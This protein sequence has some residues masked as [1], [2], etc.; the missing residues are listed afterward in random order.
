MK[1]P[2][3]MRRYVEVNDTKLMIKEPV[4]LWLDGRAFHS[5]TR[6]LGKPFSEVLIKT[7]HDTMLEMSK[8]IQGVRLAYTQSDEV[9]IL[10]QDWES[11]E[12]S[13]WFDYR[14][15]KMTSIGASM[16]TA[17]FS[18]FW[19]QNFTDFQD[20][21]ELE[22]LNFYEWIEKAPMFDCK[23]FNL[24][25]HEVP[26]WF[27]WR[28]LDWIRNSIQLCGRSNFSQRQLH[29]LNQNS[30]KEKLLEER[31]FSW[32]ALEPSYLKYGMS[33]IGNLSNVTG[34]RSWDLE[35]I[36]YRGNYDRVIEAME[37]P[38]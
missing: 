14:V 18:G 31:N 30:I 35:V 1:L 25:V 10:I 12:T 19:R 2:D 21:E 15:M 38:K 16:I 32:D 8:K 26:N 13:Q 34:K 24:P 7:M 28:Q 23:V 27:L 11:Y 20:S 36:D 5:F 29:G 4:I 3:R 37:L 17:L 22:N 6:G 33:S 9:S